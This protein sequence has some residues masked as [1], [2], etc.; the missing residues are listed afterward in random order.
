[1]KLGIYGGSFD[2]VHAG[3]ILVARAA[4]EELRLQRLFFVPAARSPFKQESQPA[5]D[6]LRLR[7]LRLALG[8][9]NDC[10]VDRQEIDRGGTSYTIETLRHFT[11]SFPGAE[12]FFLIGA[13]N[14]TTLAQWREAAELARLAVFV[15]VPRP[16][17]AGP[18]FPPTFR[19]R[20][21]KGFP[22]QVSSSDIRA[23]L[24]AGLPTDHLVPAPVA[25]ALRGEKAYR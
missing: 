18:V 6:E 1:M 4:I 22:I 24:K 19:G 21:L 25:E 17:E 10:E 5:P 23:R 7:L 8:G 15:V 12:L 2:P 11:R 13:D 14:A 16:G 3:H 20:I 9:M